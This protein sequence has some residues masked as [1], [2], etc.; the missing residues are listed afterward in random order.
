MESPMDCITIIV[1]KS[2]PTQQRNLFFTSSRPFVPISKSYT[3]FQQANGL[4]IANVTA[5]S[6]MLSKLWYYTNSTCS[7]R[8]VHQSHERKHPYESEDD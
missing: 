6:N 4:E 7:K 2:T 3:S 1:S 8:N 5:K